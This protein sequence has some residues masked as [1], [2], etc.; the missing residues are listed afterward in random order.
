MNK[1]MFDVIKDRVVLFM[2]KNPELIE[3]VKATIVSQIELSTKAATQQKA[4]NMTN[5]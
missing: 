4:V 3:I 2:N 5:C 1:K